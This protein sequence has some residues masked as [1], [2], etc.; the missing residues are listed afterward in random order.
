MNAVLWIL[1]LSLL[2]S[3]CSMPIHKMCNDSVDAAAKAQ[4]EVT[5]LEHAYQYQLLDASAQPIHFSNMIDS[6]QEVDVIFVGEHHGNQA[7]HFIEMQVLHALYQNNKSLT[8][9]LEM[10]NR[11]QQSFV[12]DYVD[13]M[14]G[15]AYLVK[16]TPS[17]NNYKGSYRPM[18]EFAKQN[19]MPIVA[20]NASA[21]IVR[22][23]GRQ[24]Q[25]YLQ[26]LDEDEK[27]WIALEPFAKIKNYQA[28]YFDFFKGSNHLS[29]TQKQ[30]SY[31]AQI[32]RDNTMAESI[33]LA[34]LASGKKPVIH[35]NGTFHS[36]DFL[37]TVGALRRIDSKIRVAV[38]TPVH[39]EEFKSGDYP[40]GDFYY[41]VNPAPDESVDSEYKRKDREAMFAKSKAKACK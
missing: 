9:S 13:G 8:L 29:A 40:K 18:V 7:S 24:G 17:W 36:E 38:I 35:L 2:M 27:N 15:E 22:C 16:E 37:G 19:L 11:D 10:F 30:Y 21:D 23:I 6:L 34:W 32:T 3:G 1:S 25:D 31:L 28:K 33:H 5:K 12:D 4:Y 41:L 26:K 14:I 39:L 20:A